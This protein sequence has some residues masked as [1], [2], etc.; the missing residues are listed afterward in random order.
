MWELHLYRSK[1]TFTV[2][3]ISLILNNLSPRE[4]ILADLMWRVDSAADLSTLI[5]NLQPEDQLAAAAITELM[6]GG[7]DQVD[8]LDQAK[9]VLDR[10]RKL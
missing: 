7:G 6:I 5:K 3:E 10:I 9:I 2:D 8:S 4:Q 1:Q